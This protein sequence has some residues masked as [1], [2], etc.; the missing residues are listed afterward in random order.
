MKVE[1]TKVRLV[2]AWTWAAGD[3]A[4]GICRNAFDGCC[5]ECRAPGDDCPILWGECKH[6][7][8]MHCIFKWVNAQAADAQKCPMCRQDWRVREPRAPRLDDTS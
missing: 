2:A 7:F 8:H 1:V 4:C 5:P 3:D 6:A